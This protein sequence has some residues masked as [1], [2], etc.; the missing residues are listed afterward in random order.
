[1][2]KYE[3]HQ[4]RGTIFAIQ[5]DVVIQQTK[6][7]VT[8]PFD[9]QVSDDTL[10]MNTILGRFLTPSLLAFRRLRPSLPVGIILMSL[11]LGG[12]L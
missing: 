1:M 6:H 11:S 12:I 5:T 7:K 8:L 9:L 2:E 4:T 10:S 3:Q